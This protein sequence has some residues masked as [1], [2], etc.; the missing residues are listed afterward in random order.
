MIDCPA[1]G[2]PHDASWGRKIRELRE[3]IAMLEGAPE[4]TATTIDVDQ[5]YTA[6]RHVA[7]EA[8]AMATDGWRL[9]SFSVSRWAGADGALPGATVFC[10]YARPAKLSRLLVAAG[11]ERVHDV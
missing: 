6:G 1:C 3:A 9:V 11:A 4:Y 2:R 5:H 8:Q 7:E 10:V